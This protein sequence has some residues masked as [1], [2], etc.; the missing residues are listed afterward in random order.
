[1]EKLSLSLC[2]LLLLLLL[3]LL[4]PP[5]GKIPLRCHLLANTEK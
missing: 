3:L 5:G 4:A 1:M 2:S